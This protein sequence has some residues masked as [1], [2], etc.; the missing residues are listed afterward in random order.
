MR[1]AGFIRRLHEMGFVP[2]DLK[3]E[4]LLVGTNAIYLIDLDRLK[5]R[6]FPGMRIIAKNLS[7]LNASFAREIPLAERLL[8]LD[9]YAKGNPLLKG[10]KDELARRIGRLTARRIK[11]RYIE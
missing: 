8:F 9:E 11:T 6:R 2:V 4:N 7:Y 3:G 1:V 5:R 10:K